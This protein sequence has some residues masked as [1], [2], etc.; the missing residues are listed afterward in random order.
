MDTEASGVIPGANHNYEGKDQS[1]SA[2]AGTHEPL[3]ILI[4]GLLLGQIRDNLFNR[5]VGFVSRV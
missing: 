5:V 4:D 1:V 3:R 2:G